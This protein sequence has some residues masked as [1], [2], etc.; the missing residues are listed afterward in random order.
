MLSEYL[1]T[2]ILPPYHYN[3]LYNNFI[4][5]NN[6]GSSFF[7]PAFWIDSINLHSKNNTRKPS[8]YLHI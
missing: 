2:V 1:D 3:T 5:K 7:S 6:G 4:T 8:M